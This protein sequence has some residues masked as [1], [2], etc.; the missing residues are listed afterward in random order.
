[1]TKIA[2]VN[3]DFVP[4]EEAVVAMEDRGHNF[5]DGVYEV[6]DIVDRV[7]LDGPAH[8]ERLMRSQEAIRITP[9]VQADVLVDVVTQLM[10]K[11]D[12]S[13]GHL[14]LQVTRG[15][16]PRAHPFPNPPVTPNVTMKLMAPKTPS[17][18]AWE[19][20]IK[21]VTQPDI[22][23]KR[24]DIK[25]IALLPNVLAMQ[26]AIEA[27]AKEAWLVDEARGVVTEGSASNAFI[28]DQEGV[29]RTHPATNEILHG[30]TRMRVLALAEELGIICDETPFT[31]ADVG[32]AKEAFM[33]NTTARVLPVV[34][35][36]NQVI[37]D[38]KPGD[39]TRR[40]AEAYQAHI[41]S[42]MGN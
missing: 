29:L 7:L 21:V 5:G 18:A 8:W 10:A 42:Q 6:V 35:V 22:R 31:L 25:A 3:G 24:C 34:R 32:E 20:G 1:M 36:D 14:Y 12:F 16:A 15:T 39:V 30:I 33:T 38:G 19:R 13:T 4:L 2:Y 23:W 17:E 41:V 11:N 28:V 26:A 37:G 40:L 27:G 9:P